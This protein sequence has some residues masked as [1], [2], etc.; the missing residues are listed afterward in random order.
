MLHTYSGIYCTVIIYTFKNSRRCF[1]DRAEFWSYCNKI[2]IRRSFKNRPWHCRRQFAYEIIS[3]FP[4]FILKKVG[5]FT[6]EILAK[7]VDSNSTPI[8]SS[9]RYVTQASRTM[10]FFTLFEEAISINSCINTAFK[11]GR[12]KRL[13]RINRWHF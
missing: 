1:S 12:S 4:W 8:N 9:S 6:E 5:R 7:E 10:H 11:I 3:W 2:A 13:S